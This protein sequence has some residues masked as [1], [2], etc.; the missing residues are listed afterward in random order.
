MVPQDVEKYRKAA[1][2]EL[3][4]ADDE[5]ALEAWYRTHLSP[6]GQTNQLKRSIG[7]LSAADRRSFGQAINQ[8][9]KELESAFLHQREM[10]RTVVLAKRLTEERIDVT[11]PAR[12]RRRGGLHPI[13]R[14]LHEIYHIFLGVGFTVYETP[15]VELDYYNF[16]ALNMPPH[17][18]ARDMQDTFYASKEVLLR[19][20]TSAGQ[21]RAMEKL[22]PDPIRII[23]PG[24]CYRNEDV[25]TRSEMQF[26]QVEGLLV[27]PSVRMSDL[28]GILLHFVR[29]M[30]GEEQ[31]IRLRGSYF[32]FTEPSV[33]VDIRCTLCGGTGCRICKHTGWLELLG[34]GLVHPV[35]LKNGGYDPEINQGIAFGM[36]VERIVMLRHS[37][38]DI[39]QFFRNDLR[40]L[41]NFR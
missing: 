33:E 34:A 21:I 14:T 23:L 26:H 31:Q 28:K 4:V 24:I 20:H 39:R 38:S 36:G 35:V 32:P 13:S 19:T 15:H 7:R 17:H 11:L 18:P 27:G 16:H 5:R 2:N 9:A 8:L 10:I 40:F 12:R 3:S 41:A 6:T 37:I 1:L 30:F 22:K 25:T 29:A